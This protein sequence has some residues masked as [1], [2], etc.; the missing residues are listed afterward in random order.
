MV[1]GDEFLLFVSVIMVKITWGMEER[2][3]RHEARIPAGTDRGAAS[4][5][6]RG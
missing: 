6:G 4:A 3:G 1:D 5:Q 2:T